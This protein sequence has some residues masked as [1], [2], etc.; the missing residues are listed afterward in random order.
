MNQTQ[1]STIK[2]ELF[3]MLVASGKQDNHDYESLIE[4]LDGLSFR[5]YS[6]EHYKTQ[7]IGVINDMMELDDLAFEPGQLN[8]YIKQLR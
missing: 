2:R 8:H 7:L 3:A 5:H 1:L 4:T 6:L